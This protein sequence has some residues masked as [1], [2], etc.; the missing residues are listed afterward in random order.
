MVACT[1]P[2]LSGTA[3]GFEVP[4]SK[5]T[6]VAISL[7]LTCGCGVQAAITNMSIDT[8]RMYRFIGSSRKG[9]ILAGK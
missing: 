6:F 4:L 5:A 2:L 8:L 3:G 1:I 9:I 7:W